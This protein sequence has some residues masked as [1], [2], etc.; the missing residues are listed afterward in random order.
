MRTKRTHTQHNRNF[1]SLSVLIVDTEKIGRN[2]TKVPDSQEDPVKPDPVK[3][4]PMKPTH[5]EQDFVPPKPKPDGGDR[6]S[7]Y[8]VLSQMD[9][10]W[11]F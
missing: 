10:L 7:C 1:D 2:I 11:S 3:P 8:V 5:P 9:I 4:D 6:I